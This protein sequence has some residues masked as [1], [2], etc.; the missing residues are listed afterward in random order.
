M[1][2]FIPKNYNF[3]I[4]FNRWYITVWSPCS[5]TCGR[6]LRTRRVHC[7]RTLENGNIEML[8]D[9]TCEGKTPKRVEVCVDEGS[10]PKWISHEWNKV[11]LSFSIFFYLGD[12][13]F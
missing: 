6:G 11:K 13:I 2:I 4:S 1:A 8:D 12:L 10:C 3:F 9:E 5:T 7:V